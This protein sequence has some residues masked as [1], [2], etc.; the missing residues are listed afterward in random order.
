MSMKNNPPTRAVGRRRTT[1]PATPSTTTTPQHGATI[2]AD[3]FMDATDFDEAEAKQVRRDPAEVAAIIQLEWAMVCR[4]VTAEELRN[5]GTLCVV[6]V[7]TVEWAEAVYEAWRNFVSGNRGTIRVDRTSHLDRAVPMTVA[8]VRSKAP[9]KFDRERE[10]D[11]LTEA[12]WRGHS[13]VGF[14]PDLGWLPPDLVTA[15]DHRLLVSPLHVEAAS[16]VARRLTGTEPK[17]RLT[18]VEAAAAGPRVLR[19]ASRPQQ[20]ADQYLRKLRDLLPTVIQDE[21]PVMAAPLVAVGD[22]ITL[23]LLAG[24]DEAVAWGT[25]LK[26]DFDA[27]RKKC[28]SWADCDRG[29]LVSGPTGCGKTTYARALARTCDVP[30]VQGSWSRWLA[31]GTGH[32]GDFM[33]AMKKTFVEARELAPCIVFLDEVD[34]FPNRATLNHPQADWDIQCVNALLAELD[35]VQGREGV[36]VVAACN[37]PHLLDPALTRSGRLDRHVRI[38]LPDMGALERIL[39]VHLRDELADTDL[40]AV[41]LLATGSSGADV[42][43]FVRGARRRARDAGRPME[44]VDIQAEIGGNDDRTPAEIR[45]SAVHE[46]G[47]AIAAVELG[48]PITSVSILGTD[49]N[50]GHVQA[51][52]AGLFPRA[53]DIRDRLVFLLA[54]RAAEE[55]LLGH[56]TAGAG[57]DAES[58]LACASWLA[59][60]A[61]SEL[62]LG[63]G[64]LLWAAVPRERA[65][66]RTVFSEDPA[67]AAL[68]KEDLADA[69][70]KATD[71][72]A[73]R[74]VAV[75]A[76]ADVLVERRVLQADD[77][78]RVAVPMRESAQCS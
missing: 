43:R 9:D 65:E 50:G 78:Q 17:V 16:E 15:A 27:Y 26:A 49:G 8:L 69:Y 41:A 73:R 33:L 13:I 25:A 63:D 18:A 75:E 37:H 38:G 3:D 47:H 70:R 58:D 35:G 23:D 36:V 53:T 6:S 19:L 31:N 67:L 71:I 42:E 20:T 54:G 62:G 44:L 64:T 66:L 2:C 22:G 68:V 60:K 48:I 55:L 1:A 51:K 57:G 10:A 76:V 45:I 72:V 5:P 30:L 11:A 46:A 21:P 12:M 24:M 14:A 59:A 28:R 4:A 40:Q 56:A 39:R 34:S 77:V 52:P 61:R 74:R 32:Q 29:V 7:P